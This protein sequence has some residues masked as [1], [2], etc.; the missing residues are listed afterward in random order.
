M[1]QQENEQAQGLSPEEFADLVA[2]KPAQPQGLSPEEFADLVAGGSTKKSL[3]KR[4]QQPQ[5]QGEPPGFFGALA[6]H[7]LE[8]AAAVPDLLQLSFGGKGLEKPAFLQDPNAPPE[9]L[10]APNP[11][12]KALR[13]AAENVYPEASRG[14]GGFAERAGGLVG[15]VASLAPAMAAGG[16]M[17][18]VALGAQM[19]VPAYYKVLG[20]TGDKAKATG[21]LL[22]GGAL[23]Q[24]G[25]FGVAKPAASL[26][27]KFAT[28]VVGQQLRNVATK[29]ALGALAGGAV[30][31]AQTGLG[32]LMEEHLTGEDLDNWKRIKEA[33]PPALLV[34]TVFSG[35]DAVVGERMIKKAKAKE[36]AHYA[37]HPLTVETQPGEKPK[38]KEVPPLAVPAPGIET[39]LPEVKQPAAEPTPKTRREELINRKPHELTAAEA[40]EAAALE[41]E[42][43]K[44][45]DVEV[46][47]AE[48]AKEWNRLH[49]QQ[50]SMN[51]EVSD[52]AAARIAEIESG[53]S[54]AQKNRLYGIGETGMNADDLRSLARSLGNVRSATDEA[55]LGRIVGLSL[56]DVGQGD[57]NDFAAGSRESI[58]A[59]KLA[60]AERVIRERDMDTGKVSAAALDRAKEVYG[61][62]A[63]EML[64]RWLEPEATARSVA[65]APAEPARLQEPPATAAPEPQKTTGIKNRTV[66]RELADMGMPPPP[67]NERAKD[68]ELHA[69][70][71][72]IIEKD[73]HAGAKLVK[74]I[75]AKPRN[76]SDQEGAVLTFEAN[77]LI[78]ERDA[79]EA[80]FNK[81]P[82]PENQARIEQVRADYAQA[83]DAMKKA[84]TEWSASG[85][86]RQMMLARDYSLAAMERSMQ[87]AKGGE[88]LTSDELTKVKDLHNKMEAAR[89]AHEAHV[90]KVELAR[91]EAEAK[92]AKLEL[93]NMA[94]RDTK[95]LESK[96]TRAKKQ[97]GIAATRKNIDRIV[98]ELV[99]SKDST[100]HS[101]V[102]VPDAHT[103]KL[104]VELAAEHLKLG[105]QHFDVWAGEM[106]QRIG[107]HIRPHLRT[108][109]DQAQKEKD[110][111]ML[112]TYKS[113]KASDIETLKYRGEKKLFGR[114]RRETPV[115]QDREAIRLKADY[116][117][118]RRQF[119]RQKAQHERANRTTVEKA[120]D[121]ASEVLDLPRAIFSSFDASAVR[122]QGGF[123]TSAHPFRSVRHA[124]EMFKTFAN[125]RAAL[126]AD[127]AI[128]SRP[129]YELG[130]AAGLELTSAD[131]LG[132]GEEAIRSNLSDKIPGVKASNRAY[133][134]YL[135]LQ[136]AQAFD[137]IVD[138]LPHKP[139]LKEVQA[140]AD[141]V[142][143]ATGRASGGGK[144][145]AQ[146]LEAIKLFWAPKYVVSRFQLLGKPITAMLD[147]RLSFAAKRAIGKEFAKYAAGQMA[148]YG[149]LAG[150]ASAVAKSRGE[151]TDIE[152]DP[153]SSDFGK[154]RIGDV[155]LDPLSGLS[156]TAT[157]L[158]RMVTGKTK[159][160]SGEVKNLAAPK[161]RVDQ[162]R[163]DVALRF[164]RSKL[165]PLQ[166]RVADAL[167][168]ETFTG[169]KVTPAQALLAPPLPGGVDDT[170]QAMRRLG[171]PAGAI[172]GIFSM[173]G[174]NLQT[175]E[176][177]KTQ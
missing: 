38:A 31:G 166:G 172:L 93:E 98:R 159:T 48:G 124:G 145:F 4:T 170:V 155:R 64:R 171:V 7:A 19:G 17:E 118:A 22:F 169:K 61:D 153:R 1:L 25:M 52:K 99:A 125:P 142:N 146:K 123:F 131:G 122:R 152:T 84:G 177:K 47:G 36:E 37:E 69:Q 67:K 94:L 60:E 56:V 162:N 91:A 39:K 141:F 26:I 73:A 161:T 59:A 77:R 30:A 2:G 136:R 160:L 103:L 126:E 83:A 112:K 95:K 82:T 167:S 11:V 102:G 151:T 5:A 54:E 74:E 108:A 51:Q 143:V 105:Y 89:V 175:Y 55:D 164:G 70:A 8:G 109:W 156:Q 174:D 44:N 49:R 120:K 57:P 144:A 58:A 168:G 139:P 9:D 158:A 87:V 106:V 41:R 96:A 72:E 71:K 63:P 3:R 33:V 101:G 150:A 78:N 29:T 40:D 138:S 117:Q 134:T 45:A 140:I 53:L 32:D 119:E 65:E 110:E 173:L 34:G 28:G 121:I 115:A 165:G 154:V 18:A 113:R 129:N 97:A 14:S 76:I 68:T 104:V 79:A 66:E 62:D 128:R 75:L 13:G 24:L 130:E 147:K 127:V 20:A 149:V 42:H 80:E 27:K 12:S 137:M 163:L 43:E 100:L 6:G 21:A 23:G 86:A 132:P 157:F 114:K 90:S 81:N 176:P 148:Y 111:Q 88:K 116:E 46:L 135:N 85:R 10:N 50:E 15:D 92:A 35:L 133:V 107:E 16:P